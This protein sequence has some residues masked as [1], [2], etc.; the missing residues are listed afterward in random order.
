ALEMALLLAL[1]AGAAL[2]ILSVPVTTVLFERGAFLPADSAGT[3]QVLAALSLGLPFATA[4]K[5]LSQTL[6]ARGA[7]RQT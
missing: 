7:L 6:F 1:P 3:A 2:L 4:G 5:V